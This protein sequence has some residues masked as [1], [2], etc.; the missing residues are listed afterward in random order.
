MNEDFQWQRQPDAEKLVEKLLQE[1]LIECDQLAELNLALQEKT[2]SRLFDW[3]DHI[4]YPSSNE[5]I[6]SL[7]S[8]GF[9][10][11]GENSYRHM[12]A[13]LVRS[14]GKR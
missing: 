5:M 14:S 11:E 9:T 2:S 4:T 8:A 6:T 13:Q 12:G 1:A 10:E 7:H 3:V